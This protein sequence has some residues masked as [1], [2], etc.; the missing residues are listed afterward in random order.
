MAICGCGAWDGFDD[1]KETVNH[2]ELLALAQSMPQAQ[3]LL[4]YIG[5]EF[6]S[7]VEEVIGRA[8]HK[9]EFVGRC[10]LAW[11]RHS[12]DG[13]TLDAVCLAHTHPSAGDAH[14]YIRSCSV[15]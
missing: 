15:Q 8:L 12:L 9:D 10:L 13:M 3:K 2:K 5:G 1:R 4:E 11:D 14:P 6:L 7:L